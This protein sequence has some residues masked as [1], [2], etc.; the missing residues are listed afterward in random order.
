MLKKCMYHK[1]MSV[2]ICKKSVFQRLSRGKE[3]NLDNL[4]VV[5]TGRT[6]P[7]T[8][9]GPVSFGPMSSDVSPAY[10]TA[11]PLAC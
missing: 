2:P 10:G 3:G 5:V 7:I 11:I 1:L 6:S 8:G 9:L 4:F